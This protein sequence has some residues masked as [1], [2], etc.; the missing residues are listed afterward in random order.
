VPDLGD[1]VKD[2]IEPIDYAMSK[3]PTFKNISEGKVVKIS[4]SNTSES[5]ETINPPIRVANQ[6]TEHSTTI[7]G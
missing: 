2:I 5:I 4:E 6:I 7:S 1:L 3:L